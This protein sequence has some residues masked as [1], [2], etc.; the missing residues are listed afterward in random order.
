VDDRGKIS[1][2]QVSFLEGERGEWGIC[3]RSGC[4]SARGEVGGVEESAMFEEFF[5][6]VAR[7]DDDRVCPRGFVSV[8][9][10]GKRQRGCRG[11]WRVAVTIFDHLNG[12][13]GGLGR[14]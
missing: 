10:F 12:C 14:K 4:A 8:G 6:V 5:A 7:E 13:R 2:W 9:R 11:K 3:N 1:M